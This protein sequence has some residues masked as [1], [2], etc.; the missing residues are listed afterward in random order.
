[1][2]KQKFWLIATIVSTLLLLTGIFFYKNSNRSAKLT[3]LSNSNSHVPSDIEIQDKVNNFLEEQL[4]K[5]GLLLKQEKEHYHCS[6]Y[7][8]G[9]DNQYIYAWMYCGSYVIKNG[10]DA[11]RLTAFSTPMRFEYQGQ[12]FQII[13]YKHPGDGNTYGPTLKQIFPLKFYNLAIAHPSNETIKILDQA[14]KD[15]AQADI[16]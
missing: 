14:V 8:Y 11:D 13:D 4:D 15:K 16:R 9:H 2:S 12:N 10:A 3:I 7:L 1:M 6:N 5:S